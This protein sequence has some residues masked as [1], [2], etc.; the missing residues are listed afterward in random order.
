MAL[1]ATAAPDTKTVILQSL[2]MIGSFV[3]EKLPNKKN[4][5]YMVHL[6]PKDFT[7]I[8]EPIIHDVKSKGFAAEKTIIFCR[9]YRDFNEISMHTFSSLVDCGLSHLLQPPE[10]VCQMFSAS[11]EECVKN[12][13]L[14]AFTKPDSCLRIVVATVA[15]GMGLDAPNVTRIIH[16]GSSESIEAYIQETGR[17]GRNGQNSTA[18]L[19]YRKRDLASNCD[20]SA[21]MKQYCSN[22]ASC[23]RKLL[24]NEFDLRDDVLNVKSSYK[25]G[26]TGTGKR[27]FRSLPDKDALTKWLP[28]TKTA[29]YILFSHY[30]CTQRNKICL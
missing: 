14:L 17:C 15:F 11:T 18:T 3:V 7:P 9:T 27:Q 26:R 1:T 10:P 2:E 28:R 25:R 22:S 21:T 5:K 29:W 16:F 12:S 24:M 4:I 20:I 19:Y 6:I 23:R 13:I 30:L 8:L